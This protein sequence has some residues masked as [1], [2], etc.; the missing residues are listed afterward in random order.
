M[1]G[2]ITLVCVD[3]W[4]KHLNDIIARDKTQTGGSEQDDKLPAEILLC[5]FTLGG[6]IPL[7]GVTQ[8]LELMR[9]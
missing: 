8:D 9:V 4:G 3:E 2:F 1:D 6:G 5:L 7:T